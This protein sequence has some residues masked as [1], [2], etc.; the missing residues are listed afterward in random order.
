MYRIREYDGGKFKEGEPSGR[1]N[2]GKEEIK[3]P[4]EMGLLS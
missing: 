1:K 3:R 4:R 2:K